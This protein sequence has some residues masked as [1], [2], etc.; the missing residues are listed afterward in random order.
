MKKV[1]CR[2]GVGVSGIS[3]IEWSRWD[4]QDYVG[5]SGIRRMRLDIMIIIRKYLPRY[6]IA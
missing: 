6:R 3:W 1:A 4:Q 2:T 5:S